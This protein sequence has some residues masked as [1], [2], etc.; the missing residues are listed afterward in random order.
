MVALILMACLNEDS[1]VAFQYLAVM[2]SGFGF[3]VSSDSVDDFFVLSC[4]ELFVEPLIHIVGSDVGF[5]CSDSL[6]RSKGHGNSYRLELSLPLLWTS[7]RSSDQ[8]EFITICP[9]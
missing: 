1:G 6:C 9:H 2:P 5:D 3:S 8:F 7:R 4:D